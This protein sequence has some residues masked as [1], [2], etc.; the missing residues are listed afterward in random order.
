MKFYYVLP[1]QSLSFPSFFVCV[2]V[3]ALQY[4]M[5]ILWYVVWYMSY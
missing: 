2:V 5:E 4:V 3:S 1:L